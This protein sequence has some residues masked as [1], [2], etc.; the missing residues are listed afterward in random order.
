MTAKRTPAEHIAGV[1]AGSGKHP[2][3]EVA[4]RILA[5]LSDAGFRIVD[6]EASAVPASQEIPAEAVDWV[7]DVVR[8][9]VAEVL[10]ATAGPGPLPTQ[11]MEHA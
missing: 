11:A 5:R 1:V 3:A 8:R 10:Q 6:G 7:A 4:E 9:T 2:A